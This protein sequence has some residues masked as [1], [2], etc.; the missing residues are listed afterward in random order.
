MKRIGIYWGLVFL[1]LLAVACAPPKDRL[2]DTLQYKDLGDTLQQEQKQ[3]LDLRKREAVKLEKQHQVQ[4]IIRP[5]LPQF[6]P[7][8]ETRI[9]ISVRNQP[10]RDVLYIIARDAGL[11]LVIEPDI[12]V[13]NTVT[14]SFENTP[15]S[16]VIEKL[17]EAYDLAWEV[18]DNVLFI[19]RYK[20]K[21]F[22][23]D[24]LNISTTVNIKSGGDILG[25][26]VKSGGKNSG[27]D[28]GVSGIFN[29]ESSLGKGIGKESLYGYVSD[30]IKSIL[31]QTGNSNQGDEYFS[32]DPLAGTLLV[33]ASPQKLK[34]IARFLFELKK[35]MQHQVVIDA[36]ILE[37]TLNDNFRYGIQWQYLASRIA[38]GT[39]V[40]YSVGTHGTISELPFTA[41]TITTPGGLENYDNA[42]NG[43]LDFLQTFGTVKVVSSPHVRACHGQPAIFT[44]GTSQSYVQKIEKDID[45]KGQVTYTVETD[46][47]FDGVLLGVVPFIL[48]RNQAEL[49][50]FPIQSQVDPQ[51]LELQQVTAAGDRITLPKVDIKNV[52]TTVKVHDGDIVILGGLIDK[53]FNKTDNDVPGIARVPLLGWLFRGKYKQEHLRELVIIMHIRIL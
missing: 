38:R 37:V 48:N 53:G 11:N 7:L 52:S 27:G 19:K 45:D 31:G 10:L 51:S 6:D 18:K 41:M 4:E 46:K 35:K 15:C 39:Q 5:E 29:V 20:T 36:Q 47:V 23:L 12:D 17:L 8:E 30:T 28:T 16:V 40:Q 22:N 42:W 25:S 43:V 24:F 1:L 44:S 3:L 33:K 32:L 2:K 9:S 14:I 50:I 26:S 34:A 21:V 13:S 49:Q